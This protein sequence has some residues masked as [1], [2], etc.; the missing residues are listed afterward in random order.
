MYYIRNQT[1][2]IIAAGDALLS[3]LELNDINAFTKEIILGNLA[4]KVSK[5]D[6]IKI[7]LNERTLHYKIQSTT[8]WSM[9][10]KLKLIHLSAIV[11]QSQELSL[12]HKKEEKPEKIE[13]PVEKIQ[14]PSKAYEPTTFI[15][16][17]ASA[18]LDTPTQN[19]DL[20]NIS[21]TPSTHQ[22]TATEDNDIEE[23]IYSKS[24]PTHSD[25]IAIEEE[26]TSPD[27]D[28]HINDNVTKRET[29]S[30]EKESTEDSQIKE[31]EVKAEE[32]AIEDNDIKEVIYS[33]STNSNL[34][35]IITESKEE[36]AST[37]LSDLDSKII[38]DED[39]EESPYDDE[40]ISA[41]I[42]FNT[43]DKDIFSELKLDTLTLDDPNYKIVD[44]GVE[45][46]EVSSTTFEIDDT[47]PIII[48]VETASKKIGISTEDYHLFLNEY[49]DTSLNLESSLESVDKKKRTSAI[50]TLIQLADVLELPKVNSIIGKLKTLS[51]EK[52][53]NTIK[54]FYNTL[55]RFTVEEN[56]INI[57]E[58]NVSAKQDTKVVDTYQHASDMEI[59]LDEETSY[60]FDEKAKVT[61]QVIDTQVNDNEE[62][63]IELINTLSNNDEN[64]LII[65]TNIIKPIRFYF[66]MQDAADDLS[67][68]VDLI[69]EFVRDFIEQ[70]HIE[71]KK[72]LVAYKNE[73]I[74]TIQKIG[75]LLKGASSNLRIN[76]L[77]E[78]LSSI[79][80]CKEYTQLKPLIV[81]YLGQLDAFTEQIDKDTNTM[82]R[83]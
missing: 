34:D 83:K 27:L 11:E 75:H 42:D 69:Q 78:T 5:E 21:I 7:S 10:G 70:A 32:T 82:K 20:D 18:V 8:L 48:D 23:V 64:S 73:D 39:K 16:P 44:F 41:L 6:T 19:I 46:E 40:V 36:P 2:H 4:F 9:F 12:P 24:T 3:A 51:H 65:N 54:T 61:P 50:D 47:S 29:L 59:D 58:N 80:F 38:K 28:I 62:T 22:E 53:Q 15:S 55:A 30:L 31:I 17:V 68:P 26:A 76:P 52:S 57:P 25:A 56:I 14:S 60:A 74:D 1:G 63:D 13:K 67:L 43:E 35:S 79:Q 37:T 66:N 81:R 71:T 49:I 33:T 45:K 72:M 77:S